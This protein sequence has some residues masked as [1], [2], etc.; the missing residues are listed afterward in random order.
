MIAMSARS[1]RLLRSALVATIF[2]AILSVLAILPHLDVFAYAL[3]PGIDLS[4]L[5]FSNSVESSHLLSFEVA[6]FFFD[7]VVYAGL[8]YV[9]F[10]PSRTRRRRAYLEYREG[11]QSASA[12]HEPNANPPSVPESPAAAPDPLLETP[13]DE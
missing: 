2:V 1:K 11:L 10:T 4:G 9:L 5:I 12:Q 3:F 6:S 7:I 13:E 8:F